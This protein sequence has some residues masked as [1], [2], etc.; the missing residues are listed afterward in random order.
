MCFSHLTYAPEQHEASDGQVYPAVPAP[1]SPH[2]IS[3]LIV[4]AEGAVQFP[5]AD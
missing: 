5:K 1:V 4:P 2:V 3:G